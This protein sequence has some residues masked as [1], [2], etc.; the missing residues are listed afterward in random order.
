M[1]SRSIGLSVIRI[2]RHWYDYAERFAGIAGVRD[3]LDVL[4]DG[5]YL[6]PVPLNI[7]EQSV[8]ARLKKAFGG[9][10][11]HDPWPLRQYHTT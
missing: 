1:V 4:P 10:R 5:Q 9:S 7:V 11:H 3:G 2:W 6:P 8:A